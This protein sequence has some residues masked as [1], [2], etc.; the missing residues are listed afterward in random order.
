MKEKNLETQLEQALT[1]LNNELSNIGIKVPLII[2]G[3]FAIYLQGFSRL[4]QT[5]DIDCLKPL[6]EELS[7]FISQISQKLRLSEKWLNDQASDLTLPM[8]ALN[9][10]EEITK[11]SHLNVEVLHRKDL[12]ALKAA[13]FFSRGTYTFKDWEDLKVL[14]P[15]HDEMNFAIDYMR[16]TCSPPPNAPKKFQQEFEEVIHELKTLV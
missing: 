5:Q 3:A 14:K 2:C 8:G 15:S 1:L 13:A 16:V 10:T 11:W 7:E 4:E 9:R 6:P 12:I